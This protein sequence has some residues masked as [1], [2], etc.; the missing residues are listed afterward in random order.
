MRMSA[1]VLRPRLAG[2]GDA[3]CSRCVAIIIRKAECAGCM[4]TVG[5]S[6]AAGPRIKS[7]VWREARSLKVSPPIRVTPASVIGCRLSNTHDPVTAVVRWARWASQACLSISVT[8]GEGS[9]DMIEQ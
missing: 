6:P 4:V 7:G 9:A 2:I 8:R 1:G 5:V 3:Q